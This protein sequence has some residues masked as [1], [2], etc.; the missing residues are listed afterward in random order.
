MPKVCIAYKYPFMNSSL[1]LFGLALVAIF[2]IVGLSGLVSAT[3]DPEWSIETAGSAFQTWRI[4]LGEQ[5]ATL[6]VDSSGNFTGSGLRGYAPGIGYYDIKITNG[7]MSGT[8]M[9]FDVSAS[10]GQGSISGEYTGILDSPFPNATS[11]GGIGYGT[12]SDPLGTTSFTDYFW[13][14][15]RLS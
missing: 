1:K 14:A 3:H 4:T 7:K 5:T 6:T 10:Y 2:A 15:T 9:T 12:I 13:E 8:S 11:A